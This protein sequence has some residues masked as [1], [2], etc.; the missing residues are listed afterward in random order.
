VR[1]VFCACTIRFVPFNSNFA[2]RLVI[3]A[4]PSRNYNRIASYEE[5]Q[6]CNTASHLSSATMSS[7]DT[8]RRPSIGSLPPSW[9]NA[10]GLVTALSPMVGQSDLP[11][12]TLARRYGCSL[13]YT[14]MLIAKSFAADV[15]Y[16]TRALGKGIR[17]Y[18]HP[19]LVQFAANT[20]QDFVAAAL[21]AQVHLP[22]TTAL[23]VRSIS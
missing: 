17:S 10:S 21:L 11:F 2:K 3:A 16:R 9:Y 20:E 6:S 7:T 23:G 12:R 18:D 8:A 14:E 15:G 1:Y 13:A 5:Q 22:M 4:G 19:L